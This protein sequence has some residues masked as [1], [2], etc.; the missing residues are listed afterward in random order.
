MSE[1]FDMGKYGFYVW[2]SYALF[3]LMLVWD[4][5]L[6]RLR[7]KRVLREV[8]QRRQREDARR[9]NASKESTS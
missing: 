9:S 4:L 6:P 8:E 5:L 2:T 3:A 7:M 1:L